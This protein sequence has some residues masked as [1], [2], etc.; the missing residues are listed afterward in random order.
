MN[1][2]VKKIVNKDSC[3]GRFAKILKISDKW[4]IIVYF[5][6][7]KS[8]IKEGLMEKIWKVR[9][10]REIYRK[11]K[12]KK[13]H[14]G[15]TEEDDA[16]FKKSYLDTPPPTRVYSELSGISM[17]QHVESQ[18]DGNVE[19]KEA[20]TVDVINKHRSDGVEDEVV[21]STIMKAQQKEV[22]KVPYQRFESPPLSSLRVIQEVEPYNVIQRYTM[23]NN[24][25]D[26]KNINEKRATKSLMGKKYTKRLGVEE[27]SLSG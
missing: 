10:F 3:A 12:R 8:S 23:L 26:T 6:D 24:E 17:Y 15:N 27:I 14:K 20:L 21:L 11:E 7:L 18:N 22:K 25:T 16:V 5:K 4:K 19:S 13:D 2:F 1:E 9:N